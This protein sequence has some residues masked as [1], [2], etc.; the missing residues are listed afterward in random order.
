MP[1]NTTPIESVWALKGN[2]PNN[3]IVATADGK[4]PALDG[5]LIT[6]I[7][8]GGGGGDLLA[9]NNLSELTATASVARTNLE[10]GA[11]DTV[12]F[13]GF[14]PPS[15]TTAEIDAVADAVVG[16]VM[17]NSDSGQFVQFTGPATYEVITSAKSHKL[18]S[19]AASGTVTLLNSGFVESGL[20][21][22]SP[23]VF[24]PVNFVE[25][26]ANGTSLDGQNGT[27][28]AYLYHD[29]SQGPAGWYDVS[30][31]N[32]GLKDAVVIPADS[33]LF[34][35][36]ATGGTKTPMRTHFEVVS[37]AITPITILSE[38]LK[39]GVTYEISVKLAI[40]DMLNG[41]VFMS[42]SYSGLFADSYAVFTADD[43]DTGAKLGTFEGELLASNIIGLSAN[44]A[45]GFDSPSIGYYTL[46]STVTPS[47]DGTFSFDIKQLV[48]SA[49]PLY[50]GKA[51]ITVAALT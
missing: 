35:T 20:I 40:G 33:L 31:V 50:V 48:S 17:I 23:D 29:G 10:L 5:S 34:F 37:E 30:D 32:A 16:Q 46:T 1:Q 45:Y 12:E 3:A 42:A 25:V 28:T 21:T 38:A 49:R 39:A 27:F 8:G 41:N 15:G 24:A 6:N 18:D 22:P 19:V 47:T 26:F 36:S 43:L 7:S 4:Y 2:Q 14:V 44:G 11:A 9:A 13:G 51:E